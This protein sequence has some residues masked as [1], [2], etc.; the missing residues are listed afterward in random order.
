M[1]WILL[2]LV[3]LF[4]FN[5]LAT[6]PFAEEKQ[7]P[8]NSY[9]APYKKFWHWSFFSIASE[10]SK[11]LTNGYGSVFS[12]NY[13]KA[14]HYLG[15]SSSLSFVPTFYVS[16]AGRSTEKSTVR[17]GTIEIG[18]FY[19]EYQYSAYSNAFLKTKLGARVYLPLSFSSKRS[20]LKT[21]SQLYASISAYPFYKVQTYYK[22]E[23]NGYSYKEKTFQNKSNEI[24]GKKNSQFYHFLSVSYLTS[25]IFS[26]SS[27]VGQEL[28]LYEKT[29]TTDSSR[30]L[31]S[32]DMSIKWN[33]AYKMSISLGL[34]NEIVRGQS[35]GDLLALNTSE[36]V[37]IT[38]ILF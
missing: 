16:T 30:M 13:F 21:R 14:K 33:M 23:A 9:N 35:W 8:H 2:S 7:S 36:V 25:D 27:R 6:V 37:V 11:A 19:S 24:M 31:Y 3:F 22:A 38:N 29:P 15:K 5:T 10:P 26:V 18:D 28:A 34:K 20:N 12:Y 32:A 17:G 4:S 1:K